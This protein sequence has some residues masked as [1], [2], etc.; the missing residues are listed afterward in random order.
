MDSRSAAFS[1]ALLADKIRHEIGTV[2]MKTVE[3]RAC[4]Q[5]TLSRC[6]IEEF[7]KWIE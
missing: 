6:D 4:K 1:R 2:G 7:P 3:Y 5:W